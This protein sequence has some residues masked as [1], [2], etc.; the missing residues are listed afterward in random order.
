M[1]RTTR[2]RAIRSRGMTRAAALALAAACLAWGPSPAQ[3]SG[4][5]GGGPPSGDPAP[6]ET[7]LLRAFDWTVGSWKGVRR[8][9]ADGSEAEMSMTV[10]TI[11]GGEGQIRRIAIAGG[12]EV[13]HGFA[14]QVPDR[15][16]GVWVRR[17]VNRGRGSFSSL[18]GRP[19]GEG[20]TW[21]SVTPGRRRESRL[22]SRRE[23]ADGWTRT[24]SVSEDGG[25]SWR[26]FWI[27]ELRRAAPKG[28]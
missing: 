9:G 3:G 19:D 16:R 13:Y 12:E 6:G 18:E 17:Y 25:K 22:V 14:V 24:M 2:P 23:G 8:D 4:F 5:S 11:L 27:D 15:E 1:A 20:S 28:P 26:I 7:S 10:E 21:T